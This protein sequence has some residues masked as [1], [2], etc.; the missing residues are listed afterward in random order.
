MFSNRLQILMT[1]MFVTMMFVQTPAMASNTAEL[2]NTGSNTN[3]TNYQNNSPF[4][5]GKTTSDNSYLDGS[6]IN[7]ISQK[8]SI[9]S[10]PVNF[11][12]TTTYVQLNS[13]TVQPGE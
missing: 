11:T 8:S 13:S 3:Q 7:S 1:L 10:N 12:S 9:N 5:Q 6:G 4:T 2:I